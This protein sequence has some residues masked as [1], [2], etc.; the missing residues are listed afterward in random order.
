M[1]KTVNPGDKIAIGDTVRYQPSDYH[2]SYKEKIYQVVKTEQH[3]FEIIVKPDQQN[4]SDNSS[5]RIIKYI[6]IGYHMGVEVWIE[7]AQ[8]AL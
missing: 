3:Y 8:Y 4:I 6:D 1:W 2:L 7:A 5:R